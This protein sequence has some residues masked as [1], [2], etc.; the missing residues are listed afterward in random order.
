MLCED[1]GWTVRSVGTNNSKSFSQPQSAGS[2]LLV[3]R[4]CSYQE[5][6][7]YARGRATEC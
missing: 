2:V 3:Q 1:P 6:L 4:C 7:A 5:G